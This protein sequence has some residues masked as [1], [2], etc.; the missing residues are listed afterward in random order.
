MSV[1]GHQ[2][3]SEAIDK[4]Y[5]TQSIANP[6]TTH[7]EVGMHVHTFVHRYETECMQIVTTTPT[8]ISLRIKDLLVILLV[9]NK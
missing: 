5:C 1:I 4:K 3:L 8:H 7:L 9:I 6:S 2:T